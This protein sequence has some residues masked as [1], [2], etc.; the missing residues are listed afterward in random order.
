MK[1]AIDAGPLD[2]PASGIHRYTQSLL[3][4]LA[5]VDAENE[6]LLLGLHPGSDAAG[7]GA[8]FHER[9]S[10]GRLRARA[11]FVAFRDG[12]DLVHGTNYVA[13][14]R[15]RI[16]SVVTVFDLS[17]RLLPETHPLRRRLWH[18]LLPGL[19]RRACRLIAVSEHTR[20]D[21]VRFHGLEPD[22]IEVIPLAAAPRFRPVLDP[23]VRAELRRRHEL[24]DAFVLYVGAVEPRKQVTR[25][26]EAT[27]RLR[28]AQLRWTLVIAGD[29]SPG[30]RGRVRAR[31]K[32]LGLIV[33]SDVIFTGRV[34]EEDLPALYSSAQ[35]LVYPSVHEG[36][37]LPPVEAMACGVPVVLPRN[38]AL[39][40]FYGDCSLMV[41]DAS[42][43]SLARAIV[44]LAERPELRAR[45]TARGA[46]RARARSWED[47]ARETL[48]VYGRVAAEGARGRRFDPAASRGRLIAPES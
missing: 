13:P 7:F 21:L 10:R 18:R 40:E 36:F 31:C 29:G 11:G 2:R 45:L 15:A 43:D 1:I 37:G 25:L 28:R 20:R 17:V 38:S 23:Q 9:R 3:A 44:S 34:S 12:A 26:I 47:V 39:A 6:Y 5:R 24:P 19:W 14:F 27:A 8:R 16:P 30:Y 48:S 33:G 41:E 42:A 46:Q 32:E 35:A 22:R 4:A